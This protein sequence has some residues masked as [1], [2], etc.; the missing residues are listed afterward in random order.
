MLDVAPGY[1]ATDLNREFLT[2]D[3]VKA[4]LGRRVPAG[5]AGAADEVA[6]MVGAIFAENIRFLTGETI[7]L[8]GGQ[9]MNH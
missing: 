1:V 9:G 2:R 4:W 6:R 5:R 7:Y 8:D 3:K